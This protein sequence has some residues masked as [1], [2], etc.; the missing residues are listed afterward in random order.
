M[1]T[2]KYG[3]VEGKVPTISYHLAFTTQTPIKIHPHT[4]NTPILYGTIKHIDLITETFVLNRNGY[5]ADVYVPYN[6]YDV[7]NGVRLPDSFPQKPG[8]S[9]ILNHTILTKQ[10]E[11][12]V[13]THGYIYHSED[14]Q[15]LINLNNF[16]VLQ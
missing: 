2:L 1:M 5:G 12:W 4:K 16:T 14:V 8:T 10:Q 15:T 3:C 9:I 6:K 7:Y 13:D 11:T